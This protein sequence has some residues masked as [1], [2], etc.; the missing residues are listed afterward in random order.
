M[1]RI[2]NV[3]RVRPQ[4][5]FV[6]ASRFKHSNQWNRQGTKK[7]FKGI[8]RFGLSLVSTLP[9]SQH[10]YCS[11]RKTILY[12]DTVYCMF[13]LFVGVEINPFKNQYF[14]TQ[15]NLVYLGLVY[16]IMITG[17]HSEST[18]GVTGV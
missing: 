16:V 10:Y 6:C 2:H 15:T 1:P 13:L 11:E 18:Q 14:S 17:T 5:F 9:S 7:N 4:P 12:L 8:V 3:G